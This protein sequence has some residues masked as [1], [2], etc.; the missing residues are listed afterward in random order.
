MS[1]GMPQNDN[2]QEFID[3]PLGDGEQLAYN[4]PPVD[5]AEPP[6]P[7]M[8][9]FR[10]RGY[11]TTAFSDDKQFIQTLESGLSQLSEIPQ[12]REQATQQSQ[13]QSYAPLPDYTEPADTQDESWNPPHYDPKWEN[14]VTMDPETGS[15][16]PINEHVNPEVAHRANEYRTWLKDQG[17]EFWNNPYDFM[18]GGLEDWVR[19]LVDDQVNAAVDQNNVDNN[20][21]SFLSQNRQRFYVVD[22]NGNSQVDPATGAELLTA[23][24]ESLKHHA[25]SA[26][27]LGIYDPNKIQAYALNMLERDLYASQSNQQYYAQQQQ[28]PQEQTFLQQA[29]NPGQENWSPNRDASVQTAAEGGMAQNSGLSF[30][31]M[32][33]P[34]MVNMGLVQQT[35]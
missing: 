16:V 2:G 21:D 14:L 3:T 28:Q 6:N 35:G 13:A 23:Q 26:R 17:R 12:L 27:E 31:D 9:A 29:A 33:M 30:F 24:G 10:D 22:Q 32:A 8:H 19:D 34:E 4:P 1:T 20:V 15:Y 11:D 7:V 5:A 18:K 25:E